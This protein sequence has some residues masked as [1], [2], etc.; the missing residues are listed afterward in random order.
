M[1]PAA[2]PPLS[3]LPLLTLYLSERCNSR[4]VTCDYW[5]YG[6]ADMALAAIRRLLP[7]LRSWT[8]RPYCS[9]A[10]SRC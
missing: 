2:A 3:R 10:A 9:R 1:Q 5:R 7:P 4:C 8:R 6:T